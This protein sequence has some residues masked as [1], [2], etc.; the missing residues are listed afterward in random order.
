MERTENIAHMTVPYGLYVE[1]YSLLE[2]QVRQIAHIDLIDEELMAKDRS[3]CAVHVYLEP[4]TDLPQTLAFLNQRL[5]SGG[6]SFSIAQNTVQEEDW[7]NSW[8]QYFHAFDVGSRLRVQ[9][10]WQDP[11]QNPENWQ[12]IRIDPGMAF[13]TGTHATTRLCLA[14]IERTLMPG[15]RFLDLGCGSGILSIGALLL[16]AKNALGVDIDPV[17]VKSATENGRLNGLSPPKYRMIEGTPETVSGQFDLIAANIVADVIVAICGQLP[18]L[19]AP[20]GRFIASGII[21]M[22]RDEV[23]SALDA[24]GFSVLEITEDEGWVCVVAMRK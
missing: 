6:I 5:N 21:D 19:L 15:A 18:A 3:R 16:G 22:R 2:E 12:V 20:G 10:S 4:Q 11:A 9:P 8:K 14:A 13:G 17:A 23:L 7:A 1:D 24:A